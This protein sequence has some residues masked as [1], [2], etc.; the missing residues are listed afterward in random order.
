M[1]NLICKIMALGL[2]ILVPVV[3]RS[4]IREHRAIIKRIRNS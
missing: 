4:S 1:F 2:L 3:V